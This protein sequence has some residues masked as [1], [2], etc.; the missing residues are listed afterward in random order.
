MT[1]NVSIKIYTHDF[2]S[3]LFFFFYIFLLLV[4]K[5]TVVVAE[6]PD[7]VQRG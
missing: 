3:I 6:L 2:F 7:A 1:A 4:F 5:A